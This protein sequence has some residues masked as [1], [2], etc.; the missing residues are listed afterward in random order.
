M[1]FYGYVRPNGCLNRS[2]PLF[3]HILPVGYFEMMD[4]L[5]FGVKVKRI[6]ALVWKHMDKKRPT[7]RA[8]LFTNSA[9]P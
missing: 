2:Q 4:G 5:D 1:A 7:Q 9:I 6:K 8:G 3:Y